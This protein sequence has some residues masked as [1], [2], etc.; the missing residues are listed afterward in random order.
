MIRLPVLVALVAVCGSLLLAGC[1]TGTADKPKDGAA[2]KK[3]TPPTPN[4]GEGE[5]EEAELRAALAKLSP[6]DQKL[7]EAQKWCAVQNKN[8]L[9]SMGEPFKVMIKDQPVF[10]CC[11]GCEKKAKAD[12]DKTLAKVAELKAKAAE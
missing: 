5:G 11:D 1:T 6:E 10:L 4:K 2:E 12:P 9:G 8:R 7:A 3:R